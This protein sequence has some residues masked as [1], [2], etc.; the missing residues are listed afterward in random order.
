M[1]N[2]NYG[3]D[4]I[5]SMSQSTV[6]NDS[7]NNSVALN[8]DV[9]T[10][11]SDYAKILA[12]RVAEVDEQF[13]EMRQNLENQ[14]QNSAVSTYTRKKFMPD[15]SLMITTYEDGKITSQT[16]KRPKLVPTP[17]YSAPTDVNGNTA[18]KMQPR[19]NLLDM[20]MM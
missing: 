17:D 3:T 13:K 20:L 2:V 11:T 15:G 1:W 14:R 12:E 5:A 9:K 16:K 18:I 4:L 19:L 10:E 6:Q 8:S 7:N